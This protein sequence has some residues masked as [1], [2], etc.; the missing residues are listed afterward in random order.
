MREVD[1]SSLKDNSNYIYMLWV[2]VFVCIELVKSLL[3][4]HK[5]L[6]K[7]LNRLFGQLNIYFPL[8][9]IEFHLSPFLSVDLMI[10]FPK[11]GSENIV[12]YGEEIWQILPVDS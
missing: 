4:V 6:Q 12:P 7:N 10:Y 8:Q 2:Y 1:S 3:G 11:R 9:Q 5:M